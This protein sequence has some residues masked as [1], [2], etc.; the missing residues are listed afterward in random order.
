M[1]KFTIFTPVYNRA[2]KIS[3]LYRSL[4]NQTFTDFEW[5]IIDDGSTD[6]LDEVIKTFEINRFKGFKY[7][8]KKNGGKHTAINEALDIAKGIMFMIVDSDDELTENSLEILWNEWENI[9]EGERHEFIG[10]SGSKGHDSKSIV[11]DRSSSEHLDCTSLELRYKY[12]VQ[13]D[14][15]EVFKLDILKQFKFPVY[16][17]EKFLTEAVIWNRISDKGYKIRWIN[18]I[19]YLCKY[20]EDGLTKKYKYLMA[21]NWQGTKLYYLELLSYD[22]VGEEI[23]DNNIIPEFVEF[24]YINNMKVSEM[25][26]VV[27]RLKNRHILKGIFN[28]YIFYLKSYIKKILR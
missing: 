25:K 16:N 5:I 4:L 19:V 7:I 6:N 17:N 1:Y 23:K 18:E 27:E 10:V 22:I 24:A 15:A 9:P 11:G 14:K 13:G 28:A 21:H 8:K 20:L 12:K 3:D 2:Y 26:Q